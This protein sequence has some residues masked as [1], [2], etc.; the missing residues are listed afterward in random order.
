M[1]PASCCRPPLTD[2]FPGVGKML[3]KGRDNSTALFTSREN[4]QK[5]KENRK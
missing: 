3:A 4:R 1:R 2:H 5:T